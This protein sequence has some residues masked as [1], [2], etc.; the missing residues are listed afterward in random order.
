MEIATYQGI[1]E[2]NGEVRLPENVHLPEKTRVYVIVPNLAVQPI[3]HIA[4]PHLAHPEQAE[5]F[6]KEVIEEQ[7]DAGV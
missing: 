4:T 7:N 5:D 3:S 6:K 1:V 2:K